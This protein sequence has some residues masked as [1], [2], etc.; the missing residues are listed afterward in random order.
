MNFTSTRVVILSATLTLATLTPSALGQPADASA[1][2]Q[3]QST[4]TTGTVTSSS[5]NTMVIR[6][7]D[8][9]YRLFVFDSH[10][11]KPRTIAAGSTVRILSTPGDEPNVRLATD[12]IVTSTPAAGAAQAKDAK[13]SETVPASVRKLERDIERQTKKY[14]AG[15]RTGVGLDPEVLLIGVHA[16]LGPFFNRNFSFRPNVEFGWGEVTKLFAVNLEGVYRLP[17]T[18][19]TGRWSA[20]FGGGPSLGFSHRNFEEAA[21]GD[22]G[23]DFGE[24]DFNTGL[25]VL[26]GVEFRSGVF[27]EMKTTVYASPHLRLIVGYTF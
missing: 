16:R 18:P 19:R 21:A 1:Q 23:I 8:G 26:A 20:Y 6:T 9:A 10:T 12:V 13:T 5:P 14:G 22:T 2:Q 11:V 24:F 4:T 17:F 7:E 15:F 3:D 25:N 27:V